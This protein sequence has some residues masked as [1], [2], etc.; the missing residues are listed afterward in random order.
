MVQNDAAIVVEH[1]HHR[2]G[3]APFAQR[4]VGAPL[5]F[6]AEG[7]ELLTADAF[8]RRDRVGRDAL[9]RLRMLVLQA[10]VAGAEPAR[11]LDAGVPQALAVPGDIGHHLGAA[12]DHEVFHAGHDLRRGQ[13]GR[14]EPAA[15]KAIERDARCLDVIAR[16]ERRHPAQI[17][18]LKPHLRTRAPDDVVDRGG[19]EIVALL[20][21][22]QH[23][24]GQVLRVHLG[25]RALALLADAA[26]GADGVDDIGVCHGT[27]FI[28]RAFAQSRSISHGCLPHATRGGSYGR[29][30]GRAGQSG[31]PFA[32]N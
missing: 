21:R 28:W 16:V 24:H 10:L 29:S 13:I 20:E 4:H 15:A 3:K 19:I 14:G 26:G 2:S 6:D 5:A 22:L 32:P 25:N 7:I 27:L 18:A 8:D 23:R 9:V 30:I 1:G 17:A 31:S 12:G 11:R